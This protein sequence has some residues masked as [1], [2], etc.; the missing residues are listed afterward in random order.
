MT[1]VEILQGQA[2]ALSAMTQAL[3]QFLA[4]QQAQQ[5]QA[6]LGMTD[7]E[8][9]AFATLQAQV[10]TNVER[11]AGIQSAMQTIVQTQATHA[12]SIGGQGQRLTAVETDVAA[13]KAGIGDLTQLGSA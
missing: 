6:V 8:A 7:V 4:A 1:L 3:T 9:Q 2:Q 12:E 10:A 11:L 5:G 13:L